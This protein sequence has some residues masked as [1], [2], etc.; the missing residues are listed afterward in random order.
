MISLVASLLLVGWDSGYGSLVITAHDR[1]PVGQ[2]RGIAEDRQ[3]GGEDE[4]H[5]QHHLQSDGDHD[6]DD[7]KSSV[8]EPGPLGLAVV[9]LGGLGWIWLRRRKF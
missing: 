2:H 5:E 3:A 1:E 8:A 9:G 6:C 4:C 7:P